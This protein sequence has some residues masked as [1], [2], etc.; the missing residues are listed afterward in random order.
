MATT[1][2]INWFGLSCVRLVA[3]FDHDEV[4]VVSDP[5]DPSRGAKLPR[6]LS[7]DILTAQLC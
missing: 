6:N 3:K 1:V 4:T 2:T 7:A 5:Y